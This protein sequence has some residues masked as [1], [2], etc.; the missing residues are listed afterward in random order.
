VVLDCHVLAFDGA[1]FV[2]AFAERGRI[3]LEARCGLE[4]TIEGKLLIIILVC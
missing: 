4:G 2:E 3:V 1:G